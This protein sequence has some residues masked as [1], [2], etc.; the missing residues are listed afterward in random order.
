MIKMT[1]FKKKIKIFVAIEKNRHR[2]KWGT[3]D[4]IPGRYLFNFRMHDSILE[5]KIRSGNLAIVA[6]AQVVPDLNA[7][8][9]PK[10]R[11]ISEPHFLR[12][13]KWYVWPT[14]K[15]AMK[16]A[17]IIESLPEPIDVVSTVWIVLGVILRF[18]CFENARN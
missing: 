13:S 8:F 16:Q 12:L 9:K 2:M 7:L 6:A 11:T 5:T 3:Q 10:M 15:D 18:S 17:H 14:V 4:F 1:F